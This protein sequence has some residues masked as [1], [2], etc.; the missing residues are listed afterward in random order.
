MTSKIFD[1]D[2]RDMTNAKLQNNVAGQPNGLL[3]WLEVHWV[4]IILSIGLVG[5]KITNHYGEA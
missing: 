4:C 5:G 1:L 2:V 3:Y